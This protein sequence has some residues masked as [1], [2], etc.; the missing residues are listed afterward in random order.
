VSYLCG[1]G[2]RG[3]S[4][5]GLMGGIDVWVHALSTIDLGIV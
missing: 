2:G 4:N 1:V 5:G 3:V